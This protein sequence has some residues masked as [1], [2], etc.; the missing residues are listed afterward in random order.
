MKFLLD[1]TKRGN[2]APQRTRAGLGGFGK[3]FLK[4]KPVKGVEPAA[5]YNA[6]ACYHTALVRILHAIYIVEQQPSSEK[7]INSP[8][9]VNGADWSALFCLNL[10]TPFLRV[11]FLFTPES[12]S[13]QTHVFLAVFFFAQI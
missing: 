2:N 3:I 13:C 9:L 11:P 12:T 4:H 5:N 8:S 10:F 1:L 7:K 6:H